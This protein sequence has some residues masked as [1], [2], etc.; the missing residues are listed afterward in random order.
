MVLSQE[1]KVSHIRDAIWEQLLSGDFEEKLREVSPEARQYLLDLAPH[2][3]WELKEVI[4]ESEQKITK[5][6][7]KM[8]RRGY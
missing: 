6:A 3:T 1:V 8:A 4:E 7:E 5:I 2:I